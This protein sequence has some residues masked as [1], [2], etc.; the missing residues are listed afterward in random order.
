M[1][2]RIE[3]GEGRVVELTRGAAMAAAATNLAVVVVLRK[4]R[5]KQ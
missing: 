3:D 4:P 1:C 2:G 5:R